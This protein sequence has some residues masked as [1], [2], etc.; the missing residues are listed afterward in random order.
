MR[1]L[2][3]SVLVVLLAVVVQSAAG[4]SLRDRD[5]WVMFRPGV[6]SPPQGQMAAPL[7][8]VGLPPSLASTLEGFNAE[9]ISKGAPGFTDSGVTDIGPN[10]QS[11]PV[12]D[13]SLLYS[14]RFPSGTNLD[15]VVAVVGVDSNVVYAE[16][17][18]TFK[19][20]STI[21]TDM[22]FSWQ[23]G[24]NNTGQAGGLIGADIDAPEAWD[25]EQGE[26]SVKIGIIDTGVWADHPDLSSKIICDEG[27]SSPHGTHVAGI[28]AAAT[29]NGLGV[30][31]V[32]WN[33][34]IC[35]RDISD[36]DVT[37]IYNDIRYAVLNGGAFVLNNS[38]GGY[39]NSITIRSAFAYAYKMGSLSVASSG[40]DAV[41]FPTYPAAYE[42]VL[43]VGAMTNT[44]E[45]SYW[46]NYGSYLDVI[47]PGGIHGYPDN[48]EEDIY[49]TWA[50]PL[51]PQQ[52]RFLAGTSM[53]A[54]FAT[55]IAALVKSYRADLENDDVR[56]IIEL[57]A[58]DINREDY[59][60]WDQYM[61][62]GLVKAA[63]ALELLRPPYALLH[64]SASGGTDVES[65]PM[66]VMFIGVP[67]LSSDLYD[68]ERHRI[69][70]QVSF[71]EEFETP[72]SVWGRGVSTEGFS[73]ENPNYGM[74]WCQPVAGTLTTAGCTLM[75]YVYKVT[76]L[77]GQPQI[78]VPCAPENV[79]MNYT[80]LA[81]NG[82]SPELSQV[83]VGSDSITVCPA[84]DFNSL[85]I[86]VTLL[87]PLGEPVV[88]EPPSK[89][90]AVLL[91]GEG[92]VTLC[93]GDTLRPSSATDENGH[94][95]IVAHH[96]SGCGIDT[97]R[98][99][100][101][102]HALTQQPVV[103]FRS[104]DL[105]ADQIVNSFD[106]IL[107]SEGGGCSDLNWDGQ[108]KETLDWALFAAH[109][110][111]TSTPTIAVT[112]PNGS[113][114]WK[115]GEE[116]EITWQMIPEEMHFPYSAVDLLLSVD[117]GQSYADTIASS[118]P[119]EGSYVWS[120]FQ[121]V[122]SDQCKVLAVARDS[123]GCNVSDA[124]DSPF[125]IAAV[126]SGLVTADTTWSS[127]ISV[128]GDVTVIEEANLTLSP[129]TKVKFDTQDALQS[130]QDPGKCELIIEGGI[131]A[132][133][134]HAE[135]VEF[136]S[137]SSTPQAG[138]W[139]GIRLRPNSSSYPL[140][141][142]VIKHA[143]NG[144]EACTTS[145]VVDSCVV[146]SFSN[147]GIKASGST[148]TI[149]ANTIDIGDTG[150]RGI[151]FVNSGGS[152][153]HNFISG[154][155]Q[156]SRYGIQSS[157]TTSVLISHNH[158]ENM[159]VGIWGKETTQLNISGNHLS[160]NSS[161]GVVAE[162]SS[163]MILRGNRI[164]DYTYYGVTVKNSAIVNL[165]A[166]P[167][168]GLNTIP[169]NPP[170]NSYC[171][172]NKRTVTVSAEYNWW[173]ANPPL[174]SYFSG[175]VDWFPYLTADPGEF[176]IR[177]PELAQAAPAA[178]YGVQN[179]PNPLNPMTTIEY[180]V[181]QDGMPVTVKVFEVSG[182][183]VKVLVDGVKPAGTHIV[184]W[185]GCSEDGRRVASGVYL[186]EVVIG[187]YRVSKK[188]VVLR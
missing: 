69:E 46:S 42:E 100:A 63:K 139:R 75:T 135:P 77:P 98:V 14:I 51:P 7:D 159:Y 129:G 170:A 157:G 1:S 10:G 131:T 115:G 145:A 40:N 130:G 187:E 148:V 36:F 78:W 181:P 18:P 83:S 123:H 160:Q 59:P 60:G 58:D 149:A 147:D 106:W 119:N 167:D 118:L 172:L 101:R 113:E 166:A 38:W 61:G 91:R 21:P 162:G 144:I 151:E 164:T 137:V 112:G 128:V 9:L 134:S 184:T 26:S 132:Q 150:V 176:A 5:V 174:P 90:Y 103:A 48:D 79:S 140:E 34:L 120:V 94:T 81:Y 182:R 146:L 11:V 49:S 188:M 4:Q 171:V 41:D 126:K 141:H 185:D 72:P 35:A 56:N 43:A 29:N 168:S 27:Y 142:C 163:Q 24:L 109:W 116:K 23:W 175:S 183:V 22:Y 156:G 108:E 50:S 76:I 39:E 180:G 28:A 20:H 138:D 102:G 86:D 12:L 117:G 178:A 67:P 71:N 114:W 93:F 33:S 158:C 8:E 17:I 186:Y 104:P 154:S 53:A 179:Y 25:Y 68:T 13:L 173:G 96:I 30:A 37:H 136:S 88:G 133:G 15:E 107:M 161:Q 122:S 57:S 74:G 92:N 45:L 165:G 127:P 125:T 19:F 70:K 55:G 99:Y 95:Q 82:L 65:I 73:T 97:V 52:Y 111:H 121:D 143:Y 85:V 32:S 155:S 47:A 89:V 87:D 31:G 124:S 62:F 44:G 110:Q 169:K 66:Q 84:G 2:K 3:V 54:P 152:A 80:V 64:E 6:I 105:N 177:M 16:R 153:S